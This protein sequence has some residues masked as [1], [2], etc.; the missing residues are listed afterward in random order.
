MIEKRETYNKLYDVY[1][2]LLTKKQRSYFEMYYKEDYSLFEIANFFEVSRNAV[3]DQL[4]KTIKKL[5]NF[6]ESLKIIFK[7]NY[8]KEQL[9]QY[10]KTKDEKYLKNMI[11]TEVD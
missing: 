1:Y 11:E 10:L 8:Q 3:F 2:K 9:E 4:N 7:E 5:E 6:E